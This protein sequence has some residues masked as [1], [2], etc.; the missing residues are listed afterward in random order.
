MPLFGVIDPVSTTAYESL[1]SRASLPHEYLALAVTGLERTD[2]IIPDALTS[3]SHT[4]PLLPGQTPFTDSYRQEKSPRST[5]IRGQ[6]P[7][8]IF[9]K[10]VCPPRVLSGLEILRR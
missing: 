7:A 1:K 6:P 10:P 3:H 5:A 4:P 9:L 2:T 8:N